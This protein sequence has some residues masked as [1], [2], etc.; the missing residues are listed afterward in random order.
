M[1]YI[2][3]NRFNIMWHFWTT[4]DEKFFEFELRES[5]LNGTK[6]DLPD[7]QAMEWAVKLIKEASQTVYGFEARHQHITAKVLSQKL[8]TA[9]MSKGSYREQFD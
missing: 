8:R 7:S 3:H 9:F 4:N 1:P 5:L 6:L 2:G